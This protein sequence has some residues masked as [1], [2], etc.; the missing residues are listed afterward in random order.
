LS[1]RVLIVDD[2]HPLLEAARLFLEQTS[3]AMK[4]AV[5]LISTH[6]EE[7]VADLIAASP[8]AGFVPKA[9]LSASPIR[10]IVGRFP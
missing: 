2:S 5:I 9:E 3:A 10:R 6:A 1:V 4:A 7:E 8:A